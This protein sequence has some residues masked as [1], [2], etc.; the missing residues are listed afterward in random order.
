MAEVL[1]LS[2]TALENS[3]L[4]I[5]R[6]TPF[7]FA[8]HGAGSIKLQ[9]FLFNNETYKHMPVNVTG[10]ILNG[11]FFNRY[12]RVQVGKNFAPIFT[13]GAELDGYNRL[14]RVT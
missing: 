11:S 1:N 4:N 9:D 7:F 13:I 8:A 12:Y 5:Q 3:G 10:L 6:S 2:Y 14:T